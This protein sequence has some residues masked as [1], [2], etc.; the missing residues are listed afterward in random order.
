MVNARGSLRVGTSGWSYAHWRGVFYPRGLP[1]S[2]WL[3]FYAERFH[4]V[5]VNGTF[6]RTPSQSTVERWRDE[7]PDDFVFAVKGSRFITH[8]RRLVGPREQLESFLERVG[9]LGRKLGIVLWQL[10][11]SLA[12]DDAL[13]DRF[14][15]E[16]PDGGPRHAVEFRNASWL[17]PAVFE[18]LA[19]HDAA[20]VNVS[21]DAL[22]ADTTTT[23]DF[24]YARFHGTSRYHGVY[25]K[26]ALRP[27]A[28][29]LEEKLAA[30][31]DCYAYFNNDFAG[32][33]PSDA[34]R[35]VSMLAR[36]NA[37]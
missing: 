1:S 12:R 11:P 16:L 28:S 14:L 24:A 7:V 37:R 13:L 5:E 2:E 21:G 10:P 33:A 32:H 15:G 31:L 4:S 8:Y 30:G 9:H 36:E 35:L 29:F 18:I 19:G 27:W 25:E 23:T 34:A 6:Y 22:R 3:R 26:P 20:L 17:D